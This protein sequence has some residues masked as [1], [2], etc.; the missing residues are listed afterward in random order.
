MKAFEAGA[1]GGLVPRI[2]GVVVLGPLAK[3]QSVE[4]PW[5]RSRT[6]DSLS[7]R[8]TEPWL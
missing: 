8:W 5:P 6:P 3:S 2:E 7:Q 4:T 1:A